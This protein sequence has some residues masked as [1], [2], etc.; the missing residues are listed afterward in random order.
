[1]R[2]KRISRKKLNPRDSEILRRPIRSAAGAEVSSSLSIALQHHG[3]A[4][5]LVYLQ[6]PVAA[7][8]GAA[9]VFPGKLVECFVTGKDSTL[10][11]RASQSLALGGARRAIG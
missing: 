8:A 1:M 9:Q 7:A 3:S 4:S 5:A 2:K 11:Q 6:P 10:R